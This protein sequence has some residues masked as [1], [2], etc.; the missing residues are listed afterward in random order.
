MNDTFYIGDT[1]KCESMDNLITVMSELACAGI[2]TKYDGDED[3]R[4]VVTGVDGR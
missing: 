3:Y 4:L 1:I 2:S